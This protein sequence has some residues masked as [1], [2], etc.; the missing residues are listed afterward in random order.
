MVLRLLVVLLLPVVL[1]LNRPLLVALRHHL[2]VVLSLRLLVV[3]SLRLPVVLSLHL[4][5]A[6]HLRQARNPRPPLLLQRLRL[7]LLVA[8]VVPPSPLFQ[9]L[10]LIQGRQL[11]ALR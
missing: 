9:V 2:P 6:L 8:V 11:V 5:V 3:L 4:L 7:H 10:H 1:H